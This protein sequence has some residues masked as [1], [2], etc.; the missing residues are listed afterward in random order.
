M[1]TR[2]VIIDNHKYAVASATYER[3]WA[4]MFNML[5]S[6]IG[7]RLNFIDRGPGIRTYSMSLILN[8]WSPDSLPY[9]DGITQTLDEQRKTLETS[10]EKIA[11][12]IN[13]YD[14]FGEPPNVHGNTT[15]DLTLGGTVIDIDSTLARVS[16]SLS[17]PLYYVLFPAGMALGTALQT[18]QY[19]TV[20]TVSGGGTQ[21]LT[22][23]RNQGGV[24]R[25][26][27]SGSNIAV[28]I[29]VFFTDLT[30]AIPVYSTVQHP[31]VVMQIQLTE[32]TQNIG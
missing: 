16:G 32:S 26:W 4:R 30:E 1:M 5:L 18:N 19:E 21:T 29:G 20:L 23:I 12:T 31:Y 15:A 24:Q 25:A 10:Y 9:Q 22:V 27:P 8:N 28:V 2:Y 11:T 7:I 6:T 17:S 14:P 3:R 13:F